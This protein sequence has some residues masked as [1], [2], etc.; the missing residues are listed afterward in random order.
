MFSK[1]PRSVWILGLVSLF[2]D[3]SSEMLYPV[4]PLFLKSIGFTFIGIGFI[5][6]LAE[7]AAGLSKI[8]FGRL[9]DRKGHYNSW[10]TAGY[11]SSAFSKILLA[12]TTL[13][14]LVFIA[15]LL[16]R[17]GKGMRTAPR[18]AILAKASTEHTISRIFALH[19]AMDTIGATLGPAIALSILY[20]MPGKYQ[21][22]FAV[23]CVPAIIGV[24]LTLYIRKQGTV[25]ELNTARISLM[26]A[27]IGKGIASSRFLRS[28]LPLLLFALINSSDVFLLLKLKQN[29][30]SDTTV[31]LIYII[32]NVLYALF[33]I[34]AGIAADR[35]G[36]KKI[37]R[38][39]LLC[40]ALVYSGFAF[41][42]NL[43]AY[44]VMFIIYAF[45][46]ACM[47]STSKAYLSG[48]LG[49]HEKAGG[50][51]FFSG[52]QSIALLIASLWTGCLWQLNLAHIA[53]GISAV[54]ALMAIFMLGTE[55]RINT[56]EQ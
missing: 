49:N 2:T 54:G 56:S 4:M 13:M 32:Y 14:P 29:G 3:I 45:Y 6:G 52:W 53:F 22:I 21:F 48:F 35:W 43:T 37:L 34:P 30:L 51:G 23:A 50:F 44:Y 1:I 17:L 40:F 26:Q 10:I 55:K 33:A 41:F 38:I 5:E 11:G 18:D 42:D 15:R 31:I 20:V 24:V 36:K 8:Y 12:F 25:K 7:A 19:R 47:E 39:G 16:D 27:L 28:A 9:S 46:A